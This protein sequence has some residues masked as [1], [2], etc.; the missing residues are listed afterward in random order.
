MSGPV[1]HNRQR[2]N[3]DMVAKAV[4]SGD[5]EE[6]VR[7]AAALFPRPADAWSRVAV[8]CR[9]AGKPDQAVICLDK[10]L[11]T[12]EPGCDRWVDLM[13]LKAD[14]LKGGG[15]MRP[16]LA[17][18]GQAL[19]A[20]STDSNKLAI[21]GIAMAGIGFAA[22]GNTAV[23]V[24]LA[25]D[26][27]NEKARTYLIQQAKAADD[28][29]TAGTLAMDGYDGTP[30]TAKFLWNAYSHFKPAAM[31]EEARALLQGIADGTLPT[32]RSMAQSARARLIGCLPPVYTSREHAMAVIDRLEMDIASLALEKPIFTDPIDQ[33]GVLP[34]YSAYAGVDDTGMLTRLSDTF[35]AVCPTLTWTAGHCKAP[36]R[37]TPNRKLRVG[38]A[39]SFFKE[40]T[41]TR[42][43][44]GL[45]AN[46]P[47]DRFEIVIIT[48]SSHKD[49]AAGRMRA[50]GEVVEFE[51]RMAYE[52][53]RR[54]VARQKLDVLVYTDIGMD[55]VTYF[56]SHSRLAP[57][58]IVCWGHPVTTGVS[59]VD[60]FLTCRSIEADGFETRY[61]ERA[62]L[63]ERL[64]A[65]YARPPAP[66][67]GGDARTL[68][69]FPSGKR[70]YICPQ[71]LFKLHPDFDALLASILSRDPDGVVG[72]ISD[73]RAAVNEPLK[74]R[75]SASLG[76][77]AARVHFMPSMSRAGFVTMLQDADVLLDPIYFGSGNTMYEAMSV[78]TPVVTLPTDM[79]RTR[80]VT[81]AY[82]QMGVERPPIA[83]TVEEY[84][85][86]A[87]RIATDPSER[88]RLKGEII[89]K[90]SALFEDRAAIAEFAGLIEQ[91]Y[92]DTFAATMGSGATA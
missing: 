31:I 11:E 27:R 7:R 57:V 23:R 55:P 87:V 43:F 92:Q 22:E 41:I 40:H 47:R 56:L 69:G 42:L 9:K 86:L 64:P 84:V 32:S 38:F 53:T 3:D 79:M 91:A 4:A 74:A 77:D 5:I 80:V 34:F 75:F 12:I 90:N 14:T 36:K 67:V 10:A 19:Q 83:K 6:A 2:A 66:M 72:L 33:I 52:E 51:D 89:T 20:C 44:E 60:R 15:E 29:A 21:I 18:L 46:L 48:E 26:P 59:T 8:A 61:R 37:K 58:Q 1:R 82:A 70:L 30:A 63:A 81:G 85:D 88:A 45:I 62:L 39:S 13:V 76:R 35:R 25:L 65:F 73:R 16:A 17:V 54:R 24:A 68:C 28:P 50:L 78:G 49:E 71:T